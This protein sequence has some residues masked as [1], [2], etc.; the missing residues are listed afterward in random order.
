[1]ITAAFPSADAAPPF[2]RKTVGITETRKVNHLSLP[3]LNV[4]PAGRAFG[5]IQ[6]RQNLDTRYQGSMKLL[7]QG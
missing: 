4:R 1:M 5:N 6:I 7:L 2:L 3:V